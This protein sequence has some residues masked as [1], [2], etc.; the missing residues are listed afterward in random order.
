METK[1]CS[2]CKEI[3]ILTNFSVDKRTKSGYMYTCKI[4]CN[5]ER[6]NRH[7]KDRDR[8]IVIWR[9][10][11]TKDNRLHG[12]YLGI[13]ARCS[14][15]NTTGYKNYGGRGIKCMWTSYKDFR[16]DMYES[17]LKHLKKY[18]KK[19]TT[20]DRIDNNGNYCKENCRWA[21]VSEQRMNQR[22]RNIVYKKK[23]IWQ[24]NNLYLTYPIYR[25]KNNI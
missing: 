20:I 9:N 17:Y 12:V 11:R 2:K 13:R 15:K 6:R 16:D 22:K 7:K 10:Y 4:C 21:T 3:K 5:S 18:G 8:F 24:N 19:Q 14:Y 25:Q 23:K 1:K